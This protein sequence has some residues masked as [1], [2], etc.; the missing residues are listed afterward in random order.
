MTKLISN[1]VN[2]LKFSGMVVRKKTQEEQEQSR[3]VA[4]AIQ[5]MDK[6]FASQQKAESFVQATG[7]IDYCPYTPERTTIHNVPIKLLPSSELAGRLHYETLAPGVEFLDYAKSGSLPGIDLARKLF[8][9]DNQPYCGLMIS[10][11]RNVFPWMQK[12]DLTP[13]SD[14]IPQIEHETTG[15]QLLFDEMGNRGSNPDSVGESFSNATQFGLRLNPD[16]Q[17]T[18]ETFLNL[19]KF[20]PDQ[21]SFQS[22]A[23]IQSKIESLYNLKPHAF[24]LEDKT[25]NNYINWFNQAT[26]PV[27]AQLKHLPKGH[28]LANAHFNQEVKRVWI[29]HDFGFNPFK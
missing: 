4:K 13:I 20:L 25:L 16:E 7:S 28:F 8:G 19:A 14:R 22:L 27:R 2:S 17:M 26:K 10:P 21:P 11:S 1:N 5:I 24:R 3:I 6:D 18:K 12:H 15:H 23:E 9:K 29:P